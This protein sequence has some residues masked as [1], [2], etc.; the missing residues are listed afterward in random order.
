[1]IKRVFKEPR[2]SSSTL[3]VPKYVIEYSKPVRNTK[4]QSEKMRLK[5]KYMHYKNKN[6][7]NSELYNQNLKL[8]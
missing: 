1:M 6:K 2:S 8:I 7:L 3:V 5:M 4:K